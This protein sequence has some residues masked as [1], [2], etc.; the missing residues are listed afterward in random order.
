MTSA[1]AAVA[2]PLAIARRREFVVLAALTALVAAAVLTLGPAPGD[3]PAHLYRT[4]LVRHGALVWDNFWYSGSYPLGSYSL[5]YYFPAALVGNVPLVFAAAV[6]ST[7]LFSSIATREWGRAALW[8]ARAFGVLAAAPMFTGLYAYSLG[9]VAMLGAVRAL[10]RGRRW[11]TV[12]LAAATVGFSPLAFAFLCLLLAACAV[13]RRSFSRSSLVLIVG[14]AGVAAVE[15]AALALF[16]TGTGS[17]PFH[18]IDFAGVLLVSVL[19][20]LLARRGR[21]AAPLVG[22]FVLWG[23]GSTVIFIVPTPLGDN[24][25][26]LGAFSFPVMLLTAG[27]AGFR[28][29]RLAVLA[30]TVALA[31][32]ITPY[33]LLI[34]YRLD[35]RPATARFWAPAIRFLKA[36]AQPGFRVEV[37]PTAAHWEAYWIPKAGFPLARGWYRQLDEVTNPALYSKQLDGVSYRRWLRSAAVDYVLLPSTALDWDGATREAA[38][39]RSSRSGLQVVFRSTNWTIYRLP[40]PTPLLTGPA[41]ARITAFGHT[42]ISG[43]VSSPG[44]YT[45]RTHFNPYWQLAGA[46]CVSRGPAKMT[47]LELRRA[48]SFSL[49]IPSTPGRLF[50]SLSD[51]HSGGC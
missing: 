35:N 26:R 34:P 15:L 22:F 12:L 23:I 32:N 21:A 17:Y 40:R 4:L 24:W 27:L 11:L 29:R 14:L 3:A 49:S 46:G 20:A 2:E 16:S 44:R 28:P 8:P 9:F 45:L 39:L 31:Y 51:G 30:L 37:V 25:T 19:G 42:T 36:H 41:P 6:L 13:A 50:D 18:S 48:G 1:A 33:L 5:L 43:T 10:Q 38:I 47:W 7:V